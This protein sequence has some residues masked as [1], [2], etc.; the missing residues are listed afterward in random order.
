MARSINP[1]RSSHLLR[2]QKA[3]L[4]HGGAVLFCILLALLAASAGCQRGPMWNLAPVEGTVT[5]GGRPLRGIE[6]VFLPDA[7]KQ[8]PRASGLTDEAGHYRLRTDA[9]DDGA[10]VCTHRVCLHDTHRVALQS[11]GRLRKEASNAEGIQ[12]K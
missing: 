2:W 4:R 12:K 1:R 11:F 5:K 3:M 7:D 9:G 10:A 6:V 8:G